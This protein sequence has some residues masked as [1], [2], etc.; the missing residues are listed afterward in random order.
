LSSG[1]QDGP[2]HD[3][4]LPHHCSH[5]ARA[6]PI[7]AELKTLLDFDYWKPRVSLMMLMFSENTHPCPTRS[8]L[9]CREGSGEDFLFSGLP[10]LS[11]FPLAVRLAADITRA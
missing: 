11:L 10:P 7:P 1:S 5:L 9:R 4:V 6:V 3:V 8:M 2:Q